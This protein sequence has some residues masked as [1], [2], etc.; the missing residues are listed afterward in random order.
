MKTKLSNDADEF[1]MLQ[2]CGLSAVRSPAA[3]LSALSHVCSPTE[4]FEC[5]IAKNRLA[6]TFRANPSLLAKR[7]LE[8]AGDGFED[9]AGFYTPGA[10]KYVTVLLMR[11]RR[12][13]HQRR[14]HPSPSVLQLI[15]QWLDDPRHDPE[16]V[17]PVEEI[18]RF[19]FTHPEQLTY[20]I[21]KETDTRITIIKQ[22][23]Q[24]KIKTQ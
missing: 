11:Q 14:Y 19:Y 4:D 5:I 13:A 22:K 2:I 6:P 12:A 1:A 10:P 7:I 9:S 16:L 18:P 23:S 20:K 24:W 17:I 3:L 15:K 21:Y 8:K